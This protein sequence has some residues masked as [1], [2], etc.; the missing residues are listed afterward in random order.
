MELACSIAT[1]DRPHE[2]FRQPQHPLILPP[3]K[4]QKMLRLYLAHLLIAWSAIHAFKHGTLRNANHV[5]NAIHSSMRQW[6]SSLNH[7]GMSFFPAMVPAGTQLY[8]GN[9]ENITIT[10]MEWL[11][12][13]PE[14]AMVFA[15]KVIWPGG[16]PPRPP[17]EQQVV[18]EP[19]Q[20]RIEPG[21]LHTYRT[22]NDIPLLYIDGSSAGKS[23]IGTLDSQDILLLDASSETGDLFREYE[24][25]TGLC[26]LA[27]ER[28]HG[29]IKGFIRMETGFEIIMCSFAESVELLGMT[30]AGPFAGNSSQQHN[31]EIFKWDVWNWVKGTSARFDGIGGDR[32]KLDYDK[33]VTA[34]AYNLNLFAEGDFPRL[35]NK[36]ERELAAMR[37]DV[38][39]V[40]NDWNPELMESHDWQAVA[41][42]VVT[43]YEKLLSYLVSDSVKT[44]SDM[45][46][47]LK[48]ALRPF[49]DIEKSDAE[50]ELGRCVAQFIP[51]NGDSIAARAVRDVT[52]YVCQ[53][54]IFLLR[55]EASV[56]EAKQELEQLMNWLDWSS[57]KRCTPCAYDEVCFIPMWPFGALEDREQPRCRNA[58]ALQG[59]WGY[60]DERRSLALAI[61]RRFGWFK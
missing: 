49:L 44:T 20:P 14:H 9:P 42:A 38:D 60:W 32:V 4:A 39:V 3:T 21:W 26:K 59:R 37:N 40:V 57:W 5:F 6:G 55:S 17:R 29:K 19:E 47:E 46:R 15:R 58:S 24:R 2:H 18:A 25:A 56:A 52:Q 7:N 10:G 45:Q 43:R 30:K 11:A 54:L 31:P 27:E 12:F 28:W 53:Q 48:L 61:M 36:S 35:A 1:E 22:T 8:H 50:A 41:D 16:K 51:P 34:F 13:E 23:S 33:M